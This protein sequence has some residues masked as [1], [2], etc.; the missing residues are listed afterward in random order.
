MTCTIRMSAQ[1]RA[2]LQKILD[3]GKSSV[4]G[5][6]R[7][8]SATKL[9]RESGILFVDGTRQ[10]SVGLREAKCAVDK[11]MIDQSHPG[12]P[13]KAP[14]IQVNIFPMLQIKGIIVDTGEGCVELDIDG[15]Q[16][17]LLEGMDTIPLDLLA[18][19]TQLIQYIRD[20]HEGKV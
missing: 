13:N 7:R 20:W 19:S 8:I 1:D 3:E 9:V 18:S 15:L 11:V 5:G 4:G 10:E 16:L 14:S 17:K 12:A 6:S 2:Q